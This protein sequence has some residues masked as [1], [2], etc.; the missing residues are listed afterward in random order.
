[1]RNCLYYDQPKPIGVIL[2]SRAN[3]E[4][5]EMFGHLRSGMGI[6]KLRPQDWQSGDE[7]WV[8]EAIAPFGGAEEMVKDLKAK[9]FADREVRYL[10]TDVSGQAERVV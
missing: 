5:A 10:A 9:V 1:M 8:V 4:V 6:T 7:I 2:W 3:E